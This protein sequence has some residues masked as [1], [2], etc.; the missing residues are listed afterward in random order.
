[1]KRAVAISGIRKKVTPHSLRHSFATHSFENGCDIRRIQK[2]LGH[3]RLDTTTIYIKVARPPE[4]QAA[5]S[6][7]DRLYQT[8]AA[9]EAPASV[10]GKATPIGTSVSQSQRPAGFKK[11][12]D[13]LEIAESLEMNCAIGEGQTPF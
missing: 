6:P 9:E 3:V 4:G 13:P 5:P 1:M 7:L 11:V 2:C 12:S 8:Y 10:N